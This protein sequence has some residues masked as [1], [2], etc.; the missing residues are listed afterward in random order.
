MQ[1]HKEGDC[2]GCT[3]HMQF[4]TV[5]CST[6]ALAMLLQATITTRDDFDGLI[7]GISVVR[8]CS[9][10]TLPF[11][12][13]MSYLFSLSDCASTARLHRTLATLHDDR[14]E[15][16]SERLEAHISAFAC[17]AATCSFYSAAGEVSGA[18]PF[19]CFHLVTWLQP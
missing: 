4:S 18:A 13:V 19:F 5:S 9:L 8:S 17:N 16:A 2:I 14:E 6:A 15:E 11:C 12:T 7:L 3:L 10:H 1:V